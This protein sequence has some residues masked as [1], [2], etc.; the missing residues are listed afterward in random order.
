[1]TAYE[2]EH[3]LQHTLKL[4][5]ART[6]PVP[7]DLGSFPSGGVA[8]LISVY[9]LIAYLVL[10][11]LGKTRSTWAVAVWTILAAAI[12]TEAYSRLYLGKHWISDIVGGLVFGTILLFVLI[13]AT[14]LLD[15]PDREPE[16]GD[17]TSAGTLAGGTVAVPRGNAEVPVPSG[18][19]Q[20][21]AGG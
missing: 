6:G 3:Q 15:R 20:T 16:A 1:M 13:A 12:Y 21:S 7:A 14:Q 19:A 10:R 17:V 4:L 18:S 11:R 5:A 9:G 8:R 2:L